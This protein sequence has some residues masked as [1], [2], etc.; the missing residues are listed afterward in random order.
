MISRIRA[1][2]SE[3]GAVG[4]AKHEIKVWRSI[5]EEFPSS[6]IAGLVMAW[7][8]LTSTVTAVWLWGVWGDLGLSSKASL[9]ISGAG[10][11]GTM[12][13]AFVTVLT[14]YQNSML[15]R[16]EQKQRE[17]PIVIEM[18]N[19]VIQPAL[20]SLRWDRRTLQSED[21]PLINWL[22]YEKPSLFPDTNLS[23]AKPIFEESDPH[24]AG[25][26]RF[27][28]DYPDI[29]EKLDK[30]AELMMASY[31]IGEMI[32]EELED[33]VKSYIEENDITDSTGKTPDAEEFVNAIWFEKDKAGTPYHIDPV[34]DE[35]HDEFLELRSNFD[36]EIA[37][38]K[39]NEKQIQKLTEEALGELSMARLELREDY[40]IE[41]EDL[42][43][44][45]EMEK[46]RMSKESNPPPL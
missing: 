5:I 2:V 23:F 45:D 11:V 28:R 36:D 14:L 32:E 37:Q 9:I 42:K 6:V 3:I 46:E 34:W 25:K 4:W 8:G 21:R 12:G 41:Q 40:G 38:L 16:E 44:L 29:Q 27:A 22:N 26:T 18:I 33:Q 1:F 10:V 17:K 7:M 24:L 15:L 39:E 13:L 31:Q 20:L 35:N 30:R 43:T 19:Q